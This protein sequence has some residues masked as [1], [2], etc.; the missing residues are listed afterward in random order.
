MFEQRFIE[1]GDLDPVARRI[2]HHF[3]EY[4]ATQ[5]AVVRKQYES[6]DI[7]YQA[8][9]QVQRLPI[10]FCNR[11]VELYALFTHSP[12]CL[13]NQVVMPGPENRPDVSQRRI[14]FL[15][16]VEMVSTSR[17][18]ERVRKESAR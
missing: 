11:V 15:P 18:L 3:G 13:G 6:I 8:I 4:V 1:N 7:T 16:L 17:I 10:R 9:K 12:I 14:Q 5:D 2:G